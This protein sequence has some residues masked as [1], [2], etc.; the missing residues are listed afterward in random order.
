MK[1]LIFTIIYSL[2]MMGVLNA[3]DEQ[4]TPKLLVSKQIMNKFAVQ[5]LD[6][7][8]KVKYQYFLFKL[9]FPRK[10]FIEY[11]ENSEK[12]VLLYEELLLTNIFFYFTFYT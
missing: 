11:K 9:V 3:D 8:I 12:Y 6:L 2:L 5:D 10:I 1:M 7:I 4:L